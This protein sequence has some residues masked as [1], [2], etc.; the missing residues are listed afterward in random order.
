[1]IVVVVEIGV[2]VEVV[3]IRVCLQPLP[4][5]EER[6][7]LEVVDEPERLG[8]LAADDAPEARF[9]AF[10]AVV[11]P[12]HG[13][14]REARGTRERCIALLGR[15]EGCAAAARRRGAAEPH[16]VIDLVVERAVAVQ[17]GFGHHVAIAAEPVA[18]AAFLTIGKPF[19]EVEVGA[20]AAG[21]AVGKAHRHRLL[22]TRAGDRGVHRK[23][24]PG[25]SHGGWGSKGC[26][27][28]N[29]KPPDRRVGQM[30]LDS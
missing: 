22:A 19:E 17:E 3:A 2:A 14:L 4:Q 6:V 27:K 10:G 18:N 13:D 28:S 8:V 20:A 24:E 21:D 5:R 15:R 1:M 25:R 11:G 7:G 29:E 26:R 12:P 30:P 9:P 16:L 23:G